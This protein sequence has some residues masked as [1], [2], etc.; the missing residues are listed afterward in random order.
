MARR[1][2]GEKLE[3]LFAHA[4]PAHR[5][6]YSNEEIAEKV[7]ASGGEIS[8]NYIWLL[9][10]GRRDNPTMKALEALAEVFGVPTAYFF[11][12]A[13]ESDTNAELEVVMAMRDAD[14]KSVALRAAGLSSQGLAQVKSIIEHIRQI[15]GLSKP[16]AG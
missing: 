16:P 14:V 15:E 13:V 5:G 1:S 4:H 10:K 8:A 7:R 3:H 6:P 9:R 12:E 11:D 2:L